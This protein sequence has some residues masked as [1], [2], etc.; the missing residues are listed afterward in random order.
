MESGEVSEQ[1]AGGVANG[2]AADQLG[3]VAHH[4]HAT[5]AGAP[6]NLAGGAVVA[7]PA[8]N[9]VAKTHLARQR[10]LHTPDIFIFPVPAGTVAITLGGGPP[11]PPQP[12]RL[13]VLEPAVGEPRDDFLDTNSSRHPRMGHS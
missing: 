6:A 12:D 10:T 9:G 7:Q 2:A 13:S 8:V 11:L 3:V 5:V 4:H 1:L